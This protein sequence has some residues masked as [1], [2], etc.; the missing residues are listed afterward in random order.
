MHIKSEGINIFS[1]KLARQ[2]LQYSWL[3]VKNSPLQPNYSLNSPLPNF[4]NKLCCEW[5]RDVHVL[6]VRIL[7]LAR[8]SHMHTYS[9]RVVNSSGESRGA[10]ARNA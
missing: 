9:Y 8:Y 4:E 1:Q 5:S 2:S 10:K 3:S 6:H 7:L